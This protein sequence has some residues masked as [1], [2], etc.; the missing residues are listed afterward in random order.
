MTTP[1]FPEII[2][3]ISP[4]N[5]NPDK[6]FDLGPLPWAGREKAKAELMAQ[7]FFVKTVHLEDPMHLQVATELRER[8]AKEAKEAPG[9]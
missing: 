8:F 9:T 3:A 2:Q 1:Y 7:G 5:G 6:F 4:W